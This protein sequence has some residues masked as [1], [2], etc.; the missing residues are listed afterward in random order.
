MK[1]AKGFVGFKMALPKWVVVVTGACVVVTTLGVGS[2]RAG[3][4]VAFDPPAAAASGST[5]SIS[6]CGPDPSVGNPIANVS[7]LNSSD[8]S[9]D[10]IVTVSFLSTDGSVFDTALAITANVKPG[11]YG[12]AT[13]QSFKYGAPAGFTCKVS[14]IMETLS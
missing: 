6:S 11:S 9:A 13:A 7:V 3:H 14:G 10:Y 2:A 8:L 4:H 5:D 1:C 12:S